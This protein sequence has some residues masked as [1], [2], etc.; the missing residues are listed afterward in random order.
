VSAGPPWPCPLGPRLR[1]LALSPRPGAFILRLHTGG[2]A[3]C[4]KRG[5]STAPPQGK[6]GPKP[7]EGGGALHHGEGRR[8]GDSPP[9]R[10][11]KNGGD[12]DDDHKS[13]FMM[14]MIT[15][16]SCDPSPLSSV[17]TAMAVA[18]SAPGTAANF[19][20]P[21]P[22][23]PSSD[24]VSTVASRLRVTPFCT[25]APSC[26]LLLAVRRAWRSLAQGAGLSPAGHLEALISGLRA[27]G[28]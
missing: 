23:T 5:V 24:V 11:P 15:N 27:G 17:L 9:R 10:R 26:I 25:H 2:R 1:T 3:V 7:P 14:A 13:S 21:H 28:S 12:S 22:P 18:I 4:D 8:R 6:L 16:D 19:V 20:F